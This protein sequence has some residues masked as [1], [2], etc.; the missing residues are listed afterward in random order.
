MA[1][2]RTLLALALVVLAAAIVAAPAQAG[3]P[4]MTMLSKV[5]HFRRQH[6]LRAVHYSHSL[7]SSASRYAHH[8]MR[9]GYFGHDSHIHASH[10]YRRLG[11]IICLQRGISASPSV[12]F[13]AWLNSGE[14]RAIILDRHFNYAGAG[15][16]SGRF[17]GHKS[18]IW[19]MHFGHP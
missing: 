4:E 16:A 15:R 2:I 17:H 7:R 19:V 3:S 9:S 14:H 1:R 11:E 13:R 12:A 8:M 18:T 6:G 10:H 5:N